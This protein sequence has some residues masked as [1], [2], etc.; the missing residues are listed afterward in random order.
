M[1]KRKIAVSIVVAF[2]AGGV[3]GGLIGFAWH[4]PARPATWSDIRDWATAAAVVL[5]FPA[6]LYQ[7]NLQRLQF[8][9]EARRNLARD[10]LLDRQRRELEQRERLRNRE[11]AEEVNLR[12]LPSDQAST[13]DVTNGSRRPIRDVACQ[14]DRGHG[15][16]LLRPTTGTSPSTLPRMSTAAWLVIATFMG[17]VIAILVGAGVVGLVVKIMNT[18]AQRVEHVDADGADLYHHGVPLTEAQF[19]EAWAAKDAELARL[20]L[21]ADRDEWQRQRGYDAVQRMSFLGGTFPQAFPNL[22]D[23]DEAYGWY[24]ENNYYATRSLP[25]R[26]GLT[27][28]L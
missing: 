25:R 1:T 14:L 2:L 12:W 23:V 28:R 17:P 3:V 20:P 8:A 15:E 4:A 22:G 9:D 5:G 13:A 18:R 27:I 6:L 7:L 26:R 16:S 24:A 11:Q 10:D 21:P 19:R